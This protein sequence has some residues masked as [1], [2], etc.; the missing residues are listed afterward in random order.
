MLRHD[1]TNST[2]CSNVIQNLV[3][4]LS[5][6]GRNSDFFFLSSKN[7]GITLPLEFITLPYRT[8]ENI[9]PFFPDR[10]LAATKILSE[11]NLEAPYKF[12]GLA[13]LSVER[14][15]TFLHLKILQQSQHFVL[16]LYLFEYIQKDYTQ[17]KAHV[18]KQQHELQ[19]LYL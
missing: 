11:A 5:V 10:L 12:K 8:T 1:R 16:L 2:P 14:E 17:L 9:Q 6:I 13:A 7:S 3:I 19:Y 4:L 15:I 18:L